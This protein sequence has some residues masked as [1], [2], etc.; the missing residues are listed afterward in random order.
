[1]YSLR[2]VHEILA[3]AGYDVITWEEGEEEPVTVDT[4]F[5]DVIEEFKAIPLGSHRLYKHQ[6]ESLESLEKGLNVVLTART[7]SGKTE[8]WALGALRNNWR[9]LAVYPTL[10]LASDQVRRLEEYYGLKGL[11]EAVVRV[12]RPTIARL[13]RRESIMRRI[14]E[15]RLVVT[16][17]AF[18]LSE[19]KR[20]AL[21]PQRGFLEGFLSSLDLLVFDELDFYGPRSAHLILA[22]I[23]IIS[24][25]L[26]RE[27]PR[28]VVLSATLGN[29]EELA[30]T[31]T[32]VTGRDTRII[33]GR[34]FKRRN[35]VIVVLGKG[36]RALRNYAEAYSSLI[37][38]KAPWILSVVRN[39]ES[40]KEHFHE[41]YEALE[42]LGLR[43][44]RPGVDAV[45]VLQAVIE[46][47]RPGELALTF[48]RS[49]KLA[50]KL[51]R[52][53]TSRLGERSRELVAVHHHLVPK[54]LREKIEERARR[55]EVRVVITV[56]TLAQGIDI[57][58][59]TRVVHMGLPMD[60]REY[61]QREGRKGRRKEIEMTETI[62]VPG[63]LWDRKLLEAGSSSFRQWLS[64]PLE[65]LY[66]NPGNKYMVLFK[67]MWKVLRG[68][69]LDADEEKLLRDM[70]MIEY[71]ETLYGRSITLS[72][73][74]IRFWNNIGF[75]EHGPPY[76]YQRTIR[77]TSGKQ[78]VIRDEEVSLRDFVEK[79]QPG[80]FD[81]ITEKII[82]EVDPKR[83][84]ISEEELEHAIHTH[85]WLARASALYE[86]VKKTWGEK[87]TLDRD[88]VN[89]L[90]YPSVVLKVSAPTRGFGEIV[91]EPLDV[92][93]IVESVKPRLGRGSRVY[94]EVTSIPL[95]APV[96]GRYRD[97]SYGFVFESPGHLRE[98]EL[99]LGLAALIAFMRIS[100]ETAIPLSLLRYNITTVGGVKLI[101]V[102]EH[103]AAGLLEK[104]DWVKV[105][106]DL[107]RTETP[108]SILVPLITAID[109]LS[110]L[111]I[112]K[113]EVEPR[114]A[115]Y[116]AETIAEVLAG[117]Q[118]LNA[119]G[120]TIE[121]PR[122][123]PRHGLAS[124]AV[125]YENIA[126]EGESET[127]AAVSSFDGERLRTD[128]LRGR[129][130]LEYSSRL[131]QLLLQHIDRLAAMGM[132]IVY[133][134][135]E[136]YSV[137][138]RILAASYAGTLM[139]REAKKKGV[140]LDLLSLVPEEA[141]KIPL[142]LSIEPRAR[143]YVE[144]ARK[145]VAQRKVNELEESLR[146]IS[147]IMAIV[148]YRVALAALRGTIRLRR[149]R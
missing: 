9:T 66:V 85:T 99:R 55:G 125:A 133:F 117:L 84:M 51:Y 24:K 92:E 2:S 56:R 22:M 110:G 107:R 128:V 135:E 29:P 146:Q 41:V 64:L 11:R 7:G 40:L 28:V 93:W 52:E 90:V 126:R 87:P 42:A 103:E 97:Y 130:G 26:S 77:S 5:S 98:E 16:N 32:Y 78:I 45:E 91:E 39:E 61:M 10:A 121:H 132:K 35:R 114:H 119:N 27:P 95:N 15:A 31:L 20:L 113:G 123:S 17:P 129:A 149:T 13:G 105:A 136:Q 57:G 80:C 14:A 18:L 23:E 36:L 3:K 108:P 58:T 104:I 96:N 34:P 120:L 112:L 127:I 73:K 63:G 76:G 81:T 138:E 48:T 53:I 54:R 101:H 1:M 37:A 102:W 145:A 65:K 143:K 131:A 144:L 46:A 124:I 147:R 142:L 12:D 94:H 4:K 100:K 62:I 89:G 33:E 88:L 122:P 8:A 69:K 70:G 74:G 86:R 140:L 21:G 25:Y 71:M 44:P 79:Y 68:I 134:G 19:I 75:Y 72:R 118:I 139:L 141:R 50:E 38:S 106:S 116:M 115:L 49:I 137:I 43:P 30:R 83:L 82:V 6:A 111:R 148:A 109:P 67:A 60:L 47:T 59:V